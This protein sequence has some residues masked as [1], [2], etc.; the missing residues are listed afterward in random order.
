MRVTRLVG[1]AATALALLAGFVAIAPAVSGQ[2]KA[3]ERA[4]QDARNLALAVRPDI[5]VFD[6]T[7]PEIGVTIREAEKGDGVIV[8]EVRSGSPASKAGV[9][10]GDVI[11]EFDGEKVRS[12]RQL[13][14]LVRETPAGRSVKMAVMRDGKRVDLAVT[15]EERASALTGQL[16]TLEERLRELPERGRAFEFRAPN[17]DRLEILPPEGPLALI[18]RFSP[19]SGRLGAVVQEMT[20]QLAAYFG[21]K[22]GVLVTAVNDG[23]GA[24]RAGLKAGD[25]ITAVN[26]RAVNSSSDLVRLLREAGDGAEVTIAIVRDRRPMTVNVKLENVKTAPR[27]IRRTIIV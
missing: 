17:L 22:D 4:V 8:G 10:A 11:V 15:P 1:S 3:V 25:V 13:T 2:T 16:R 27:I 12:A 24:A 18:E 20:P 21:A 6:M 26:D 7:G 5:Q 14:R 23:S 19:P 9:R